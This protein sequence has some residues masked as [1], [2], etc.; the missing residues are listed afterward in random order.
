M[1]KHIAIITGPVIQTIFSAR[2]TRELW[3]SSYLFSYLMKKILARL[4]NEEGIEIIVPFAQGE[5]SDPFFRSFDESAI[6]GDPDKF[7][8]GAG[9]FPDKLILSSSRNDAFT[10]VRNAAKDV[11]KDFAEQTALFLNEDKESV[12]KWFFQFF[13]ICI[14]EQE[15]DDAKNPIF[16]LSQSLATCELQELFPQTDPGYLAALLDRAPGSFLAQEA[17]G[18]NNKPSF[19]TLLEVAVR[20]FKD[21]I[22]V[23][24][25][26][27]SREGFWFWSRKE[28][29][30]AEAVDE[31]NIINTL[32]EKYPKAFRL[33]HHY[34]AVVHADG[35]G[36]GKIIEKLEKPADFAL[37]SKTLKDFA[38]DAVETI[39]EFGGV[40]VYAGGDDLLFFAPAVRDEKG[41]IFTLLET[42]NNKIVDYFSG[43][44]FAHL[45]TLSFGVTI[46]YYKFPL[47]EALEKSRELLFEKAKGGK[48]R[49]N[50][51]FSV[52]KH[53]GHEWETLLPMNGDAF[54]EFKKMLGAAAKNP[55]RTLSSINYHVRQNAEVYRQIGSDEKR[56]E[57]FIDNSF[58]EAVH[59]SGDTQQYLGDVKTLLASVFKQEGFDPVR[60]ADAIYA[61]LRTADFLTSTEN[62]PDEND[63]Q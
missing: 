11:A 28:R 41:S 1:K 46:S 57:A 20:D 30:A 19:A 35:D 43:K 31:K 52:R 14:V 49:N 50:I 6:A 37:F 26:E 23:E 10:L 54:A 47:F 58:D 13:R 61:L 21:D 9:L 55:G 40:P 25:L 8:L 3:A 59:G 17:F 16:E 22:K 24:D 62:N 18:K 2:Y 48:T 29:E 51:A 60:A 33:P 56:I 45:P 53:S 27:R 42:L 4:R 32:L 39:D 5:E 38:L 63:E 7:R 34:V 36:I 15:L 12:R 44:G